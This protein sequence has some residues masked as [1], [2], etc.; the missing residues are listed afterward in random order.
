MTICLNY[1]IIMSRN[2]A[3]GSVNHYNIN[4]IDDRM[5]YKGIKNAIDTKA[6]YTMGAKAH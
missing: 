1:L 3:E 5:L 2:G 4:Y 6:L